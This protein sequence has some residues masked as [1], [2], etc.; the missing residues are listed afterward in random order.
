[1]GEL[2]LFHVVIEVCLY[3]LGCNW[4]FWS[5][6][7]MANVS[8]LALPWSPLTG[9]Y[10]S[11]KK[12]SNPQPLRAL[13]YSGTQLHF[14]LFVTGY[15]L[16]LQAVRKFTAENSSPAFSPRAYGLRVCGG[17]LL[18]QEGQPS[19]LLRI[20]TTTKFSDWRW[21]G[22]CCAGNA[23]ITS[24]ALLVVGGSERRSFPDL[25]KNTSTPPHGLNPKELN[26]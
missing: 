3:C 5:H 11:L 9:R 6:G 17:L 19:C 20:Q 25:E 24:A 1:M 8:P 14:S 16:R 15:H 18:E 7:Y 26:T 10:V 12:I 2:C 23:S 21:L 13:F 22:V 4:Q